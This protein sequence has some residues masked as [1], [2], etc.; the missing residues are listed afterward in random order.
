MMYSTWGVPDARVGDG[1]AVG[2][3][4]GGELG[5]GED[6]GGGLPDG[7]GVGGG[8]LV[9]EGVSEGVGE[10]VGDGVGVGF[11]VGLGVGATVGGSTKSSS[12]SPSGSNAGVAAVSLAAVRHEVANGA[13]RGCRGVPPPPMLDSPLLST[14]LRWATIVCTSFAQ[15]APVAPAVARGKP[16]SL[17]NCAAVL[18]SPCSVFRAKTLCAESLAT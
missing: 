15:P 7:E 8:Q 4:V 11:T 17:W 9:G 2:V 5:E 13:A 10:A 18:A 14:T 3:G 1:V 16:Q 12:P 6:V